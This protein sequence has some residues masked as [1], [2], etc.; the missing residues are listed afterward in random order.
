MAQITCRDVALGYEGRIVTENLS[1]TVNGGEYICIVGENGSGK[2]TLV[3]ALL[4]LRTPMRGSITL[5][6]GLSPSQIGYLP[7]QTPVQ[8]DFPASVGEI[9]LSGCL[10]RCGLRPFYTRQERAVADACMERLGILDMKRR[11]YRDLSGGQQQRVL[12]CRALCATRKMLLLD[13]PAAGLDP[14]TTKEL[15]GVIDTLHRDGI[16]VVMVSH[17]IEA[18][19]RHATHILHIGHDRPFYGTRDAYLESDIGRAFAA[20]GGRE[21]DCQNCQLR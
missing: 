10:N 15:Y 11:C 1:F 2:S 13:E 5:G 17:D 19:L 8:R 6:D 4:H 16:T 18:A 14:P 20:V 21:C 3:K 9:V 12:L 7:Q